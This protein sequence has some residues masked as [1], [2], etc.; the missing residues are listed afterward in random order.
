MPQTTTA[1]R[2]VSPHV[3]THSHHRYVKARR[4][5]TCQAAAPR[6]RRPAQHVWCRRLC[7][8]AH[9]TSAQVFSPVRIWRRPPPSAA[10][11]AH[12]SPAALAP[13]LSLENVKER[14]ARHPAAR[15]PGGVTAPSRG[16]Y[17]P[18]SAQIKLQ[19]A[20]PLPANLDRLCS[21]TEAA[22]PALLHP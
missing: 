17:Q 20:Q 3:Y 19:L 11:A 4:L 8:P 18:C 7:P 2:L 10:P 9:D 6:R 15:R 21:D 12:P 22:F 16:A 1:A 13:T 14:C 5:T